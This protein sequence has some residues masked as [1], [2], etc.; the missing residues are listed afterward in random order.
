MHLPRFYLRRGYMFYMLKILGAVVLS[1]SLATVHAKRWEINKIVA[2]VNGANILQSQLKQPRITKNGNAFSLDEAIMEE[3]INQKAAQAQMLPTMADVDRQLVAFKIQNN[4]TDLSDSEFEQELKQ[5]GFN[6]KTYKQQ[7]A[8]SIAVG[9]VQRAEMSEKLLIT[10]QEVE[11]YYK[12]H[13]KHTREEFHLSM[14]IVPDDHIETY[15]NY[16]ADEDAKW[17]DLGHVAK[18]D[19]GESFACATTMK[20]GATSELIKIGNEHQVIK[21][22]DKRERRLKILDERYS[23]IERTLQQGKKASFI[24]QFEAELKNKASIIFL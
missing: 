2:R 15:K 3:L 12:K 7:L 5:H 8:R 20:I 4:L 17:E 24:K 18:K 11:E 19:L 22:I 23:D 1:T 13:P 10:T 6:L 9:N 21:L 14:C 16:I